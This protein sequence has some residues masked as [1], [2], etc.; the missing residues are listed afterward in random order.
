MKF[1]FLFLLGLVMVGAMLIF[2]KAGGNPNNIG[3]VLTPT[4][5]DSVA[6]QLSP[7]DYPKVS[8]TFRSDAKYVTVNITNVKSAALE[9][10]LIYD[11]V[12][13][14]NKIQA[15]VNA[16]AKL[17]GKN[18]YTKEQLLGSESS[19]K[20]T[21]HENIQNATME[22]TLRDESGRSVYSATYPFTVSAGKTIELSSN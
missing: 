5:T 20:F 10:N 1:F 8:L 6:E 21:Y 13:K 7:E 12:V 17:E 14:K 18:S 15:G 3:S 2:A 16:S 22:L 19:G 9:Y 4:P 11:A